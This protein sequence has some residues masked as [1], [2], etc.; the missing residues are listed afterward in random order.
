MKKPLRLGTR[1][2]PLALIQ[3]E[4]VHRRLLAAHPG[5]E[6]KFAIEIVPL[7]TSGDW[8]PEQKESRFIDLGGNKGLFTRE[9][10]EA[11]LDGR[12]DLAVHSMKDVAG[13]LPEG[14]EIPVLLERADP[15]DAFIGR[16]AR[17]LDELPKG[18][19]VGTSSLRRQAQILARRP[20]L[21][22][23]PLRGNVDTRL[24]KIAD[25]VAEA[26][27]LAVAGLMRLGAA[28]K[29]SSIMETDF[30]LPAPAQGAIGIEIR[31]D[32][33]ATRQLVAPL[34]SEATSVCVGAER[35]LL[36][37]LDGSCKT[38]FAALARLGGADGMTIEALVAKPD[39]TAVIKLSHKGPARNFAALGTELGQQLKDRMPADFLAV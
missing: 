33:Q 5:I 17:T 19:A 16:T 18:A 35:A 38:P 6:E 27:L 12:I 31:R 4:E 24:R 26:T 7:R 30:M 10:E 1:G 36:R 28:G 8:R 2:S 20:D 9:I 15:R 14:L 11:L 23:V 25:G 39:G 13:L 29:I 34:N 21:R 22:V 37:V 32:D 3:A